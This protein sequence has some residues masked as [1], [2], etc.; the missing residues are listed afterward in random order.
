MNNDERVFEL[1]QQF[2]RVLN[3]FEES[4]PV[5]LINTMDGETALLPSDQLII[6][7]AIEVLYGPYDQADGSL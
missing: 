2:E 7:D 4:G 3:L 6:E 5:M 1:E